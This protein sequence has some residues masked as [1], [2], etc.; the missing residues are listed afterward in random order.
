M[1]KAK[2]GLLSALKGRAA[3][4][5][6][7]RHNTWFDKLPPDVQAEL[8]EAK[9]SFLRGEIVD[10]F[11]RMPFSRFAEMLSAEL[12]EREIANIGRQGIENWLK[13]K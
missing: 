12:A 8:N 9:L 11:G 10:Q 7:G 4:S 2:G 6:A 5:A 1:A 13:R 3:V